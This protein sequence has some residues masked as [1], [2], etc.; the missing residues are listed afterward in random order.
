MSS[1]LQCRSAGPEHANRSREYHVADLCSYQFVNTEVLDLDAVTFV[2]L[3]SN[4]S[5]NVRIS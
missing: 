4:P 1:A 5:I 2:A 3:R